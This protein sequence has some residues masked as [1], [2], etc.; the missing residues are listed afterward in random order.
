MQLKIVVVEQV[1][2]A[3]SVQRSKS[4]RSSKWT[5]MT[6]PTPLN[7]LLVYGATALR[8]NMELF[9]YLLRFLCLPSRNGAQTKE[10]TLSLSTH[11]E[12]GPSIQSTSQTS[13]ECRCSF[14]YAIGVLRAVR[15]MIFGVAEWPLASRGEANGTEKSL[16]SKCLR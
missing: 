10:I 15:R 16:H 13:N 8:G 7:P 6:A 14:A 3:S 2:P 1:I 4:R 5:S 12:S 11:N 9:R